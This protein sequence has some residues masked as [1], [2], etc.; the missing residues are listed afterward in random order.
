M[1]LHLAPNFL[2]RLKLC[3]WNHTFRAGFS[4][5]A[6]RTFPPCCQELGFHLYKVSW[7]LP[8]A[9]ICPGMLMPFSFL[10][11][12]PLPEGKQ[13]QAPGPARGGVTRALQGLNTFYRR[14]WDPGVGRREKGLDKSVLVPAQRR[15][16]ESMQSFLALHQESS[17]F[18]Q[19]SG[20]FWS[21]AFLATPQG[22]KKEE[23][24]KKKKVAKSGLCSL[25]AL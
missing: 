12:L 22:K 5:Q 4:G 25:P 3:I 11:P 8:A 10:H 17:R 1:P 13:S 2:S 18:G 21:A 15:P 24:R 23:K 16:G 20:L 14:Q 19:H 9:A 7:Y 6:A